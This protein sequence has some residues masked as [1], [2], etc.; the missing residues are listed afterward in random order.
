MPAFSSHL[1]A[2]LEVSET[3]VDFR[4]E[5]KMPDAAFGGYTSPV[6]WFYDSPSPPRVVS[7]HIHEKRA[8]SKFYMG[9]LGSMQYFKEEEHRRRLLD[10]A[11][12]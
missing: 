6:S 7:L 12:I 1:T 3:A 4:K 5:D 11:R 9:I 2:F 8:K 10:F